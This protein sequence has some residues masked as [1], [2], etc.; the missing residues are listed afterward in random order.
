MVF[1]DSQMAEYITVNGVKAC[2]M[3]KDINFSI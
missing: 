1:T 3:V 2:F